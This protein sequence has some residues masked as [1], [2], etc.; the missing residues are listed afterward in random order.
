MCSLIRHNTVWDAMMVDKAFCEFTDGD[1]A[2]VLWERKAYPCLE[3]VFIPVKTNICPL[4]GG[5]NPM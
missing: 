3:Y 4:P 2:E 5:R 1:V